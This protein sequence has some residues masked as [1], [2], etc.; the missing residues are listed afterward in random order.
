MLRSLLNCRLTR[1]DPSELVDAPKKRMPLPTV[2]S[3][4]EIERLLVAPDVGDPAGLRDAAMLYVMYASGLRVS[5][6]VELPCAALREAESLLLV[7]GKGSKQRLVPIGD[8]A[9]ELVRQYVTTVR[10][11]WAAEGEPTLFVT[12]RGGLDV[13]DP[14]WPRGKPIAGPATPPTTGPS[15]QPATGP[16]TAPTTQ[17]TSEP[18]TRP[19]VV[20]P[21]T[22]GPATAP[23]APGTAPAVVPP[24][25]QPATTQPA[26]K[27]S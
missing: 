7:R 4:A 6:L 25:T 15:T 13:H 18:T 14:H 23:T 9:C 16:A 3:R 19:A 2:L 11:A 26:T 5:E 20:P 12:P 17:P 22:T 21:P 8:L 1:A 10:A 24:A 27:P